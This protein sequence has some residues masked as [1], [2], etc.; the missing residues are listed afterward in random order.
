MTSEYQNGL[1]D[2]KYSI[3]SGL[4]KGRRQWQQNVDSCCMT[5]FD[6]FYQWTN[7]CHHRREILLE[8][9]WSFCCL[10]LEGS[11]CVHR[12]PPWTQSSNCPYPNSW[13]CM[14]LAQAG[15]RMRP[16][17]HMRVRMLT[18]ACTHTRVIY[19]WSLPIMCVG[20]CVLF[21]CG[22]YLFCNFRSLCA[23]VPQSIPRLVT[24]LNQ[25]GTSNVEPQRIVVVAF[26]AEVCYHTPHPPTLLC[27]H[28]L[29]FCVQSSDKHLLDYCSF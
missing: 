4:E 13:F 7:N 3:L 11:L 22:L 12:M 29:Y 25:Y 27:A 8:S 14:G 16:H 26:Y 23:R 19:F 18:F 5:I 10:F 2:F 6:G 15:V 17:T 20:N 9:S 28:M 1:S 24:C 21:N